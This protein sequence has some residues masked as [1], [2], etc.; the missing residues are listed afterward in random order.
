MSTDSVTNLLERLAHKRSDRYLDIESTHPGKFHDDICEHH[1]A[2]S[3]WIS[4]R[5]RLSL[6]QQAALRI[7]FERR[8]YDLSPTS[9]IRSLHNP[10]MSYGRDQIGQCYRPSQSYTDAQRNPQYQRCKPT[11]TP[12]LQT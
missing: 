11:R 6:C 10:S 4:A 2:P 12:L 3:L 5:R 9:E 8:A 1:A 7:Y